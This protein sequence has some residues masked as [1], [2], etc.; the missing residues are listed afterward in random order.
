VRCSC[1]TEFAASPESYVG[2]Q[3]FPGVVLALF[4]CPAPCHSTRA[5]CLGEEESDEFEA[6]AA[7]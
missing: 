2:T 5:V 4:N 7:E 3:L 6:I 1:G